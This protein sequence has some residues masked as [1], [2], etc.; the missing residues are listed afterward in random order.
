MADN[1][2]IPER[3][4]INGVEYVRSA[5]LE[6]S[7]Y[8]MHD[9]HTFDRLE[10]NTV[11]QLVADARSLEAVS[12]YGSV[13]PVRLVCGKHILREVGPMVHLRGKGDREVWEA[14][15]LA[16]RHAVEAD[17]DLMRV[18]AAREPRHER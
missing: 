11:D 6:A 10:G 16:W 17:A 1:P 15:L 13:C 3:L 18:I 5:P 7:L 8:Y 4:T 14:D 12:P 9:N 2:A